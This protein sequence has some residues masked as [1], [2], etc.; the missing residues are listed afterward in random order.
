VGLAKDRSGV[1]ASRDNRRR[2]AAGNVACCVFHNLALSE[3]LIGI[4]SV[5]RS[6]PCR[7]LAGGSEWSDHKKL[8]SDSAHRI[9]K[10]RS[11]DNGPDIAACEAATP[12]KIKTVD[13]ERQHQH[14]KQQPGRD[15]A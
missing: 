7:R 3:S 4:K 15:A 9:E 10:R 1:M 8:T 11:D 2:V 12:E 14:G 5:I 6:R 13:R